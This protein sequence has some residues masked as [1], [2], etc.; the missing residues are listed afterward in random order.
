MTD[1]NI[2]TKQNAIIK[3]TLTLDEFIKVYI[4]PS[5]I[6]INNLKFLPFDLRKFLRKQ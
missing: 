3:R 5:Q 2:K 6:A 1:L 4:K